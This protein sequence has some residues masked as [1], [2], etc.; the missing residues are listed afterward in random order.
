MQG[1]SQKVESGPGPYNVNLD[2]ASG[3]YEERFLQVPANAFTI[4]GFIQFTV[5][6]ADPKWTPLAA[7]EVMG[8]KDS[9]YA[10]LIVFVRP[11][12]DKI[13]FAVRDERLHGLPDASFGRIAL[14]DKAIPFE[15]RLDRSGLLQ[16]SV[17]GKTGRA[18]SVRPVEITRVRLLASTGHIRFLDVDVVTPDK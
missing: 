4:K 2:P 9:F 17:L 18:V 14:T 1:A 6:R 8:P 15:L 12:T 7:V 16:G 3:D 11:K 5:V 10:G 13:E